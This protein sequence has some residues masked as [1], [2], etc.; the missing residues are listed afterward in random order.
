MKAEEKKKMYHITTKQAASSTEDNTSAL[1]GNREQK[2]RSDE[3]GWDGLQSVTYSID[4]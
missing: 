4:Q 2:Q 3:P 1:K